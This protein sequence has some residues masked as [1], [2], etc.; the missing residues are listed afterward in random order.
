M[1]TQPSVQSPLVLKEYAKTNIKD[2]QSCL[3]LLDFSGFLE[4]F[5]RGL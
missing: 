2:F 1:G 3:A 4:I 5:Y